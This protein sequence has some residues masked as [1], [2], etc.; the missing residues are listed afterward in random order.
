LTNSN[1]YKVKKIQTE[2]KAIVPAIAVERHFIKTINYLHFLMELE[3]HYTEILWRQRQCEYRG[4]L[5][6]S[7]KKIG[8]LETKILGTCMVQ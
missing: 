5:T 6:V 4:C 8:L 2:K 3:A 7:P 1:I